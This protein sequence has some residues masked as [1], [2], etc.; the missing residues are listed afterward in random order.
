M[1]D[2]SP[3]RLEASLPRAAY[4]DP[5]FYAREARAI[6]WTQW[7]CVGRSETVG[8]PG[9]YRTVDVSGESLIVVRGDDGLLR[10]HANV[11]RHRGSR[12]LCG[13]GTLRGAIRCPYHGWSYALDGR[14]IAS[15]FIAAEVIP[16]ESKALYRAGVAEWGGFIFVNVF[17]EAAT[18]SLAQQLDGI[19]DRLQR[20]PLPDL[21]VVRTISYEVAANW[22]VILENYNECYH[23]AGVHPELCRI[24]PAFR[25]RG[26]AEL[27]WDRGIPHREGAFTFTAS[28]T[29]NRA[30]FPGLDEDE[31]TRHKGELAYPNM[32]ISLAADH[33]AA[34]TLFPRAPDATTVVC[35]F[36]FHPDEIGS[37]AFDPSDAVDFWDLVNRQDWTICESVQS[38]MKSQRFR[39]GYYAPMEDWSLDM[40]RYIAE[41]LGDDAVKVDR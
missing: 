3:A 21:R 17:P 22:K 36:L 7:F 23:C 15:P 14:L 18:R 19:P 12:L 1:D 37:P 29:T 20:Y 6:F 27:D 33:V 26:G 34:F 39:Y 9:A 28:G 2:G 32:M 11:C 10:A 5:E 4:W 24:V 8:V 40:R 30:P 38:G 13:E 31:R 35:D 16:E 41:H 25:R